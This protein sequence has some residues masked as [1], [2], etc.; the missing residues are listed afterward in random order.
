[1]KVFVTMVAAV[2]LLSS[3]A[4]FAQ[5]GGSPSSPSAPPQISSPQISQTIKI[6]RSGSQP[7]FQGP[8]EH[9][10]GSVR[11]DPLFAENPP[12]HMSGSS[13]TFEPGAR[14]AWH[15]HTLGQILIPTAG[16]GWVQQWGGKIREIRPGDVVWIPPGVKH[17]HGATPTTSMTHI[18]LQ[19]SLNGKTVEWMEKVTDE[20]YK[21]SSSPAEA[22]TANSNEPSAA[23]KL[24][25]DFDPKLADLT[26]NVLYGDVWQRPGLSQRD[27]SLITVAAL[28]AL[29]RPE[30]LRA[31]LERARANGITK[32]EIIEVITHLA[33]YAGWPNAVNAVAIAREVYH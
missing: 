16:K 10:T 32:D 12:A 19:E 28:I 33:F 23:Q 3:S 24:M 8:F 21:D 18:A 7:P 14:T 11:I 9:F 6:T 22:A 15:V 17:W 13:I 1:M 29:N 5:V 2:S 4:A 26:D 20:E 27:R 31:H 25:G 30:Q